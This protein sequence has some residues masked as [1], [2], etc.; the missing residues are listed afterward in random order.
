MRDAD[1]RPTATMRTDGASAHG[2]DGGDDPGGFRETVPA[3]GGS[4]YG[5]AVHGSMAAFPGRGHAARWRA[6]TWRG[7]VC[8]RDRACRW[9]CCPAG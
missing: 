9:Q 6:C 8:T 7:A 1:V 2:S 4:L 3:T 5:Q